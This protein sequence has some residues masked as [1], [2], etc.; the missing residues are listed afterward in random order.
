MIRK[1]NI[2]D[3][4][5]VMDIWLTTN[6]SSHDFIEET[7]WHESFSMVRE[8]IPL[9]SVH[10][11]E[12]KGEVAGFMGVVQ[13]EVAGIFIKDAHQ[14]RGAGKR[15]LNQVKADHSILSLKVYV[16]NVRAL[17]FYLREGFV[18]RSEQADLMTGE[19]EYVMQWMKH[20]VPD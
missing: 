4:D 15:L 17:D 19:S 14:S 9:A 5:A 2:E 20:P 3:L 16:K 11:Y 12:L 10:V 1:F 8:M 13:D 7:Y 18:I 6:I